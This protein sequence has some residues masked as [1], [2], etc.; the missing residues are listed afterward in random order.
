MYGL[1]EVIEKAILDGYLGTF[2]SKQ[3]PLKIT[4]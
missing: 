3:I 2:S 4:F 1:L